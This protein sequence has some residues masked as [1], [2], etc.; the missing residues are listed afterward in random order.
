LLGHSTTKPKEQN[1]R[2]RKEKQMPTPADRLNE[3]DPQPPRHSEKSHHTPNTPERHV[4]SNTFKKERDD[5][6]TVAR[7]SPRV[8]P[9]REGGWRKGTP[10]A[11]KE[12][13]AAPAG[14]TASVPN[15]TT[16]ISPDP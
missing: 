14:V 7:T 16:G 15:K 13:M 9:V 10:E 11:L 4:Q 5:N 6:A 1:K 12:G 2:K 3:V 8:S